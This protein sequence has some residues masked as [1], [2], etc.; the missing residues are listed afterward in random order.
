MLQNLAPDLL[1]NI[2]RLSLKG[3]YNPP[4][5]DQFTYL[6]ITTT[7]NNTLTI[8]W[9][10]HHFKFKAVTL[11]EVAAALLLIHSKGIY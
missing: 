9:N 1:T 11:A 10:S 3:A 2:M 4:L 6:S 7:C 5:L 8:I